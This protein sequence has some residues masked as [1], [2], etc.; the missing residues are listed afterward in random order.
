MTRFNTFLL[1]LLAGA[2]LATPADKCAPIKAAVS[3][4]A[5]QSGATKFC[6][7]YLGIKTCTK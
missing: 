5:L 4:L 7:S 1:P 6:S 3:L 2:A